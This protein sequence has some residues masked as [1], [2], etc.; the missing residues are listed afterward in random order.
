MPTVVF[1]EY[2]LAVARSVPRECMVAPSHLPR[3]VNGTY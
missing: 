1:I 3:L 2:H